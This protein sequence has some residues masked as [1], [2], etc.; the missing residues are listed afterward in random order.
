M[1]RIGPLSLHRRS[2]ITQNVNWGKGLYIAILLHIEDHGIRL[3]AWWRI[4]YAVENGEK[5]CRRAL[6]AK[7]HMRHTMRPNC[8]EAKLRTKSHLPQQ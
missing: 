3:H 6:M 4:G 2:T 5:R 8:V 7:R 1:A